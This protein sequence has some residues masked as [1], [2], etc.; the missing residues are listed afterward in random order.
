L[1]APNDTVSIARSTSGPAGNASGAAAIFAVIATAAAGDVATPFLAR[2]DGDPSEIHTGGLLPEVAEIISS[3]SRA[4]TI[5]VRATSAAAGSYDAIHID[6]FTGTAIPATHAATVPYIDAEVY[7]I[8]DVGGD[9]GDSTDGITYRASRDGGNSFGPSMALGS[10]GYINVDDD[11]A[12]P[13][14]NTR[15]DLTPPAAQVTQ[16][17]TYANAVRTAFLAHIIYTTGTVHGAADTTSDDGVQI[18]ATNLATVLTLLPTVLAGMVAH[19]ARG[20]SVHLAADATTSLTA[21][22]AAV[23]AATASG[24]AQDAIGATIALEA[25][26]EAHEALLTAHTIADATNVVSATVPTRG[27]VVAGDIIEVETNAPTLA[28]AGLTACFAALEGFTLSKYGGVV[29]AG[30]F[31]PATLWAALIAGLDGLRSTQIPVTAIVEARPPTSLETPT[32]YRLALQA[33]WAAYHDERVYVC[34][35]KH[36]RFDP[37]TLARC[38]AQLRRSQLAPLAARLAALDYGESPGVV[39]PSERNTTGPSVFGGTLAG[40]KNYDDSG[41]LIGHD[42]RINPGLQGAGFGVVTTFRNAPDPLKPY[43]FAPL[44]KAPTG[45]RAPHIAHQRVITVVEAVLYTELTMEI[46]VGLLF[47]PGRDTIR[48]DLADS[49]DALLRNRVLAETGDPAITSAARLSRLLVQ[50]DRNAVIDPDDP[51][52]PVYVEVDTRFYASK[53]PVK[54]N[55]NR[56][57]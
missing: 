29:V 38:G 53:F 21:A 15:I 25:A 56:V 13:K 51:E 55:V 9:V 19:F 8:F 26:L 46:E 54:L 50:T 3:Y 57:G 40:Y 35:G 23:A 45:N 12:S 44:N 36:G 49:L 30:S 16:L 11:G 33:E 41:N 20:T 52:L 4:A 27:T 17:V 28:A 10:A 43:V 39:R 5:P 7:V 47:E 48:A 24:T 2:N 34:A 31:S 22:T 18:A 37:A 32:T 1:T 14:V 6:R 42:E